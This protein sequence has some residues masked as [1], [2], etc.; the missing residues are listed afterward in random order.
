MVDLSD[1]DKMIKIS[2]KL[3][4]SKLTTDSDWYFVLYLKNDSDE[5]LFW[6]KNEIS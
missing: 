5:V 2:E 1:S 6:I 4:K 3:D